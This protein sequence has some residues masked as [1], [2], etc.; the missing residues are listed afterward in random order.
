[1]SSNGTPQKKTAAKKI[2]KASP[3][4]KKTTAKRASP[5]K[6]TSQTNPLS[7]ATVRAE[8]AVDAETTA[9]TADEHLAVDKRFSQLLA[10]RSRRRQLL[11]LK[12]ACYVLT[13]GFLASLGLA[14]WQLTIPSLI[15]GVYVAMAGVFATATGI[16]ATVYY[17]RNKSDRNGD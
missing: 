8:P 13:S 14:I 3:T 6:R 5:P 7:Q 11:A 10:E 2:A 17:Q 12:V 16:C 4:A 15:A 9:G 1:M